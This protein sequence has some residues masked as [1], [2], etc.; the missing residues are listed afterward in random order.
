MLAPLS[1]QICQWQKAGDQV[2]IC[3]RSS[4]HTKN[5]AELLTKHHHQIEIL[6]SPLVLDRLSAKLGDQKLYLCDHPLSQGFSLSDENI[7]ILSESE[8]F[9]EMRLGGKAKKK[10]KDDPL[11]FTELNDGDIVVHRDHGLGVYRG[12]N[13]ITLQSVI[14]DFM[15]IEYRDG[16]KLYL[17]VDRL[18]LITRYQGI[19][20]REPKIDKLGTQNWKTTKAKVKDEVWKVAQELLDIYAKREIREGRQFTPAGA[21]VS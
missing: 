18:N 8:L 14:N 1:E 12:L 9:G 4:R 3:C 15:L 17:P 6:S 13:T 5:L 20:D 11:R 16:D 21:T 2:I 10:T 19:S 7:H